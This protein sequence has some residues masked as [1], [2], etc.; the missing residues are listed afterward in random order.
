M[1]SF[2]RMTERTGLQAAA[3]KPCVPQTVLWGSCT[4][5]QATS[6]LFNRG[7]ARASHSQGSSQANPGG[8][9]VVSGSA[10]QGGWGQQHLTL[11]GSA[12]VQVCV[13]GPSSRVPTCPA[14]GVEGVN[15]LTMGRVRPGALGATRWARCGQSQPRCAVP[16][17]T[18]KGAAHLPQEVSP[19][20]QLQWIPPSLLNSKP[21]LWSSSPGSGHWINH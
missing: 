11:A 7:P 8:Q 1:S 12:S 20:P 5:T 3:P 17:P 6:L 16:G 13:S 4:L 10:L 18:G 14:R 21:T 9:R 19:N 15:L 2:V